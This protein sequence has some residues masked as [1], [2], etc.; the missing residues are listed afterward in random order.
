MRRVGLG[1]GR[2]RGRYREGLGMRTAYIRPRAGYYVAIYCE[3][4][5]SLPGLLVLAAV[6]GVWTDGEDDAEA[7]WPPVTVVAGRG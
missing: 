2:S 1:P 5:C 4:N 6:V 3:R 7:G